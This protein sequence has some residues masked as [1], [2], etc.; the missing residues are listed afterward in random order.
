VSGKPIADVGSDTGKAFSY[1]V[2]NVRVHK[3]VVNLRLIS[4][5]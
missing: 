4:L 3:T 5:L 2:E 1:P